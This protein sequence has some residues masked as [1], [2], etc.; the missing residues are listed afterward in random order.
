MGAPEEGADEDELAPENIDEA[1]EHAPTV[2]AGPQVADVQQVIAA[3]PTVL[4]GG[5]GEAGTAAGTAPG[6]KEHFWYFSECGA[7]GCR[8]TALRKH[9]HTCTPFTSLRSPSH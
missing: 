3:L 5:A 6:A 1:V 8:V 4:G 2:F 7:V 9:L